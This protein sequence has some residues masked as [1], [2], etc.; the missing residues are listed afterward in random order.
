[1][2][3][4]SAKMM[5]I[6]SFVCCLLLAACRVESGG[7]ITPKHFEVF[8]NRSLTLSCSLTEE[9][10]SSQAANIVFDVSP[11]MTTRVRVI[12]RRTA[13]VTILRV[14]EAVT[15]AC[16]VG[17]AT[18]DVAT[19]AVRDPQ[20]PE[21]PTCVADGTILSCTWRNEE[22]FLTYFHPTIKTWYTLSRQV[23]NAEG[24]VNGAFAYW[25]ARVIKLRY[26][27]KNTY[28]AI[29]RS[30]EFRIDTRLHLKPWPVAEVR[31]EMRR[32]HSVALG[33]RT[34]IYRNVHPVIHR[35]TYSA[36]GQ[37][38]E[39]RTSLGFVRLLGLESDTNYTVAVD[40]RP[41]DGDNEVGFWSDKVFINI[42][43]L[44]ENATAAPP[45][46]HE[47]ISLDAGRTELDLAAIPYFLVPAVYRVRYNTSTSVEEILSTEQLMI[48]TNLTA[49]TT[50]EFTVD[51]YLEPMG[52]D[53]IVWSNAV[54]AVFRTRPATD[55]VG[56]WNWE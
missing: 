29:A 44:P 28:G 31:A 7:V 53:A 12:N 20:F 27:T 35:V 8:T 56:A 2:I 19:V 1:M 43:T 14:T 55:E 33:W 11:S 39:V 46:L 22:M 23:G 49:N 42:T 38:R 51:M 9:G 13:S 36:N 4:K 3:L 47:I 21:A 54:T 34:P 5:Y 17:S 45:E 18:L 26:L 41:T 50:Y 16:R 10:G 6:Y 48:I 37:S 32:S 24:V 15:V 30:A 25:D 40:S 52:D